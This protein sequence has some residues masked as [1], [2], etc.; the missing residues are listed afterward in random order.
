MAEVIHYHPEFF[1]KEGILTAT[2]TSIVPLVLLRD[3]YKDFA[4][5]GGRTCIKL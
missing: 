1:G 3:T 4:P 2:I 5:V